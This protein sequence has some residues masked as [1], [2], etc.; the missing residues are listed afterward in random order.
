[1]GNNNPWLRIRAHITKIA[2]QLSLDPLL[3]SH[4]LEPER[5]ITVSLPFKKADGSVT[6]ASGY[7]VQHNSILGPYKGGLRYHQKVSMD[8]VK[9]FALL[10]TIKNALVNVPL[11]GGKGG[12]AIDPKTLTEKELEALTRLFI[13]RLGTTIGPEVDIPAP[14]VNTNAKIMD[15]IADEY[16]KITGVHS[17]AVVTGKTL[18]NGGSE[19][20]TEATGL[21]GSYVLLHLLKTLQKDPKTLT[22][23]VQGFGNVGRFVASFLQKAGCKIVGLSDS[24]GGIYIPDGIGDIDQ[25]EKCKEE[26]GYLAGCYCVGSVCDIKY[27]DHLKGQD[28]TPEKLLELP[29]DIIVPAA[30]ENVITQENA[31]KIQAKIILEMANAPTTTDADAILKQKEILVIPDVLANAGGVTVSYFEW[32]QNRKNEHWSKEDVLVKLKEKMESATDEVLALQKTQKIT[33]R[34]AAYMVALKRFQEKKT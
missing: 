3:L 28:I 32:E 23:A 21:G 4:L 7:R 12:I 17:P 14:D 33:L 9:A 5:T 29:V 2:E 15:W 18:A 19:G 16:Q 22:V 20:R 6:V 34:D 26:K 25:V 8:E 10:M 31:E 30:L 1:M 24:K 13:K 11:G 27:K